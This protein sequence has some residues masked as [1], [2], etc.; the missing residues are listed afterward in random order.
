MLRELQNTQNTECVITNNYTSI[1]TPLKLASS[2]IN[3]CMLQYILLRGKGREGGNGGGGEREE[4]ERE[5]GR[6]REGE[7]IE[8][9]ATDV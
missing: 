8:A 6:R 9:R 1:S 5:W 3:K 7:G 2:S 4:R